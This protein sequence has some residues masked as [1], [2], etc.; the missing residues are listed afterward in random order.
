VN[1]SIPQPFYIQKE[2]TG[3]FL[4]LKYPLSKIRKCEDWDEEGNR[5][6]KEIERGKEE[7]VRGVSG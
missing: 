4:V 7:K 6:L 1:F 5:A 2:D 3:F